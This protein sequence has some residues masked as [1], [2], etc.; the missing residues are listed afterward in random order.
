MLQGSRRLSLSARSCSSLSGMVTAAA[1]ACTLAQENQKTRAQSLVMLTI[2]QPL[3]AAFA[4][5]SS[6]PLV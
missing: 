5:A 2:V 1:V 4:S 3:V 6:A